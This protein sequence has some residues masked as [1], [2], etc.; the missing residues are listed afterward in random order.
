MTRGPAARKVNGGYE[1]DAAFFYSSYHTTP[2]AACQA[3]GRVF[4]QIPAAGAQN[5]RRENFFIKI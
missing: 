3:A 5:G 2:R 4:L 1:P